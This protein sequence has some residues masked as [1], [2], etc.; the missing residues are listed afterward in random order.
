MVVE[1]LVPLLTDFLTINED[2]NPSVLLHLLGELL[3]Q[4]FESW[5]LERGAGDEEEGRRR[6]EVV[7][8]DVG[9]GFGSGRSLIVEEKGWAEVGAYWSEPLRAAGSVGGCE[10]GELASAES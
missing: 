8:G 2:G 10:G 1:H 9:D 6:R 4:R 7:V 5:D 3:D